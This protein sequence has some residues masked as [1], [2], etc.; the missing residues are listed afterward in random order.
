MGADHVR[1]TRTRRTNDLFSSTRRSW[2]ACPGLEHRFYRVRVS[3]AS[4]RGPL[5]CHELGTPIP[6]EH[7]GMAASA[8]NTVRQV[9][10]VVGVAVLGSLVNS[11]LTADLSGR[12]RVLGVP[13]NF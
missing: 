10:D 5:D 6:A 13:A 12:L 2:S 8:A 4:V 3:L 1:L 11:D 9:G 7:L